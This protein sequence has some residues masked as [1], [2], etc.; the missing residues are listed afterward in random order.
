MTADLIYLVQLGAIIRGVAETDPCA[1]LIKVLPE[2][3]FI[4]DVILARQH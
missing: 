3:R 1:Q 4:P 2:Q